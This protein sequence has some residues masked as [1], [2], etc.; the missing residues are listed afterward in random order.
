[1][2][3]PWMTVEAPVWLLTPLPT[4]KEKQI[5]KENERSFYNHY[6]FKEIQKYSDQICI[7]K[8]PFKTSVVLFTGSFPPEQ[9]SS[10]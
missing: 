6:I 8:N 2:I 5:L 9:E 7:L 1:M 10:L 4:N 3:Q